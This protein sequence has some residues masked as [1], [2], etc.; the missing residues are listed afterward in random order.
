MTKDKNELLRERLKG[1]LS[2]KIPNR[3]SLKEI[4]EWVKELG[5]D[6]D[7]VNLDEWVTNL[8]VYSLGKDRLHFWLTV[9]LFLPLKQIPLLINHKDQYV[10]ETARYRLLVGK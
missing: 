4:K 2:G 6:L 1:I 5:G 3:L 9:L 7:R 10:Q 8:S